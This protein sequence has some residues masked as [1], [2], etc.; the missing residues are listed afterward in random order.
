MSNLKKLWLVIS[1]RRKK[2]F[3]SVLFLM[4]LN[5][6]FEIVSIGSVLP[7]VAALTNPEALSQHNLM[8]PI[9]SIFNINTQEQIAIFL[10]IAF[11]TAIL[12]AAMIRVTLL[13]LTSHLSQAI[14]ADL[15]IEIYKRTL[16]QDYSVHI[17]RNSSE[18]INGILRKTGIVCDGVISPILV[19]STSVFSLVGIMTIFIFIDIFI[20]LILIG[21][22][23]SIYLAILFFTKKKIRRNSATISIKTTKMLKSLN[24][25]LGGIRDV[26]LHQ[27]QKFYCRIY[28]DSDIQ[29]RKA[30]ANSEFISGSPRYV[31]EAIGM[32]LV[33]ILAY[34]MTSQNTHP[35]GAIPVLA[36]FAV[37]A[38]RLLPTLQQFYHSLTQIRNAAHSFIDVIE[39]LDQPLDENHDH[40]IKPI[41]FKENIVFKNLSFSYSKDSK[42]ILNNVNLK[43]N[44]GD[45]IGIIGSTGSGKSTLLDVLMGLLNPTEGS[46]LVDGVKINNQNKQSW[47]RAISH[48]PQ[49]VFLFNSPIDENIAFG[50]SG[51]NIDKKQLFQAS[52]KAQLDELIDSW[53]NKYKTNIGEKGINISGGQQQRI[54][55]AR[56]L[57]NNSQV[58]VFD[59][60]TS[61]LDNKTEKN[62]INAIEQDDDK[63]TVF[64]IAHRLTT[65]KNCNKILE[66]NEKGEISLRTY[67]E[68][69]Q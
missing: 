34:I 52:K 26:L 19:L 11:I 4:L 23:G 58:L 30:L 36:A 49:S 38:Q 8:Q 25:G 44:K 46:I 41:Q 5:S 45:Q 10:S 63:K 39:L 54:G 29:V 32:T 43:I 37:G 61:A 14:A 15:S 35:I 27:S 13:Y 67:E 16:Y 62:V 1:K 50:I 18:V 69:L 66:L 3:L 33:A 42:N 31:I 56:A 48:V 12:L 57:Y 55:I 17:A 47:Q 20:A 53:P 51:E 6:I 28:G 68:I 22:V 40:E 7:F 59:E 64:M 24:E 9:K 2:Q 65:L 60:A 21:S